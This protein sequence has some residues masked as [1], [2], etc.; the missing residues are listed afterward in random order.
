[1][2]RWS[3][4]PA[5]FV[6]IL[7]V[8]A[9]CSGSGGCTGCSGCG[10]A[11]LPQGFQQTLIIPNA[12]AVRVTRP[13]FDFVS[14]NLGMVASKALGQTAAGGLVSFSPPLT[15]PIPDSP[16]SILGISVELCK[17]P[18]TADQCVADIFVQMAN[19]HIDA[20][21]PSSI[22]VT[23]TIP[24]KVDD[25]PVTTTLGDMDIGIGNGTC[26][27][28]TPAVTYANVPVSVQ[29]PLVAE[30]QAPRNGY[31]KIDAANAAI[32][33]TIDPSIVQICGGILSGIVDLFKSFVV[34]QISSQLQSTLQ[35]Q[36]ESQLCTKPDP[37]S[38]P[39][40][41]VDT[42]PSSDNSQCVFTSNTTTCLPMLLGTEGH[43]D[44]GSLLAKYSPGSSAGV[45]LVLASGGSANAAPGCAANQTW[46]S[47][48]GCQA[49]PPFPSG[50]T[51]NGLT[52]NAR[53]DDPPASVELRPAV[54]NQLPQGI[55]I[56][57]ELTTDVLVPWPMGDNGPDVSLALSGRFLN[58]AVVSAYNAGALCLGVTTESVQALSTGYVSAVV[59]SLKDLTFEP[60]KDSSAAA[61]AITTRPQ[62]PPALAIGGG[63]DIK[64]D[65]LL[66]VTLPQFAIDFYVW[67]EDR[68]IRAFTYT[69]DLTIPVNLQTGKDP[70]TNP[71]GGLLPVIGDVSAANGVVTNSDLV[72]EDPQQLASSLS[73]LLSGLVGQFLGNGFPPIDVS[74]ALASYGLSL[75]VPEGG[76][77]KLSKGS[78][79]FIGIFADLSVAPTKVVIKPHVSILS[80]GPPRGDDA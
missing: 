37:T 26:N 22:Q 54:Q 29:L 72:W 3:F 6:L 14:A 41:P 7:I 76:I 49:D 47:T 38:S 67:S 80:R 34:S 61:M 5:F 65:P 69:A 66:T 20:I 24:V 33:A 68:F 40:C 35:K 51:P 77:R 42:Q 1:M 2:L 46:T 64:K 55:P 32:S 12:A 48:G 4:R 39:S 17:P 58:Y 63:T 53:R 57:S 27:G 30:T 16:T 44:I 74:S 36:L 59:P 21:T 45:D 28:S 15:F 8:L 11:P 13:G 50:H 79:D 60:G 62:K 52:G 43:L 18:V 56:P 25:I 10:M 73:A 23:G 78:D 31:T 75:T 9:S 71:N 70:K 19:L